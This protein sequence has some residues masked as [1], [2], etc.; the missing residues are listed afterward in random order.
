M[1]PQK[2]MM[3]FVYHRPDLA[4][5][6]GLIWI[7]QGSCLS[8]EC[9]VS[10]LSEHL[11]HCAADLPAIPYRPGPIVG[12]KEVGKIGWYVYLLSPFEVKAVEVF[13]GQE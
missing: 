1:S 4:Q 13:P 5:C 3:A 12:S 7:Q 8:P 6:E 11:I 2:L 9:E 10:L